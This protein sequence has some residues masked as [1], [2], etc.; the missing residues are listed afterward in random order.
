MPFLMLITAILFD[1]YTIYL[2]HISRSCVIYMRKT[3]E[4]AEAT[5]G[6]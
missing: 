4:P 2:Y 6:E 3:N 1:N 5:R